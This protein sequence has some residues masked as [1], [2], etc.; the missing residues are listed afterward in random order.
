MTT[1]LT[2]K[3]TSAL[4]VLTTIFLAMFFTASVFAANFPMEIIQPQPSRTTA[5]RYYKAYPGLEYNVKVGVFGGTFPFVYSLTTYPSG[6]TIN[7]DTGVITWSNPTTSGSPHNVTVSVKD[8]ENTTVT[9]SWTITVTTSGFYFLDA[10]NGND[11]NSGT[12]ASPWKTMGAWFLN[13]KNDATYSGAFLYYRTGTYITN[14]TGVVIEDGVRVPLTGGKKPVVWLGYPGETPVISA[15]AYYIVLYGGNSNVYFDKMSMTLANNSFGIR[16]D[17][18]DTGLVFRRINFSGL[19]SDGSSNNQSCIMIANG[20][21]KS[22]NVLVSENTTDDLIN[23]YFFLGYYT[24][25][26]VAEYNTMSNINGGHGIAPKMNNSNWS[27]RK[28]TAITGMNTS[29]AIWIDTY[30]T[31]S[32]MDVSFNNIKDSGISFQ[33]GMETSGYGPVYSYR[34]TY[35]GKVEV[36]NSV[37]SAPVSFIQDTINNSN[38]PL[39]LAPSPPTKILIN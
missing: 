27:I 25:K 26:V 13:N 23:A 22:T 29:G 10:A 4:L 28:N 16:T 20:G 5:N 37:N 31:T 39:P 30:P 36:L 33:V 18:G 11:G 7:A 3:H 15:S 19:H 35:V 8:S 32:N 14:P 2:E 12:L 1:R 24:D 17:S 21:S 9:R 38:P 6:M 34:N